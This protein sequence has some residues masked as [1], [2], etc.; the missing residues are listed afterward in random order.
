MGPRIINDSD[1]QFLRERK[2]VCLDWIF[3]KFFGDCELN[4][5]EGL[6]SPLD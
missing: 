5:E 6:Q 2:T 4:G 1:I 3:L